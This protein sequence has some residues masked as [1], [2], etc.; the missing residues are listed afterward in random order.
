M[1]KSIIAI[2]IIICVLGC[3]IPAHATPSTLVWI[4]STDI[5][6]AGTTHL[7]YDAYSPDSG[8][9]LTDLGLTFGTGKVEYGVDYLS[10]TGIEDPVRLNAKLLLADETASSP[11][12]AVGA[13]DFGGDAASNMVYLVGSKTFPAARC[14]FGVCTG[15]ENALGDDN[16]M[17]LVGLDKQI[18]PKWW[19]GVDYQSGRSGFGALNAG[20]AYCFTPNANLI[21]GYDWY[22]DSSLADTLTLQLDVNL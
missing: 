8:D 17:L 20:V 3:G 4:P 15:K 18:S 13:M 22:N 11:R 12:L 19:A 7:G 1:R 10:I 9:T 6:P 2:V 21:A 16:T 14:T 5:Q